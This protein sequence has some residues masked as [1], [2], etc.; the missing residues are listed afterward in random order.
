[1]RIGVSL[2]NFRP[3]KVGGIET[4]Y[5]ELIRWLPIC[6]GSANEI[7]FFTGSELADLFGQ[8]DHLH[9]INR[10]PFQLSLDRVVEAFTPCRCLEIE[11]MIQEARVDVMFYPHQAMFPINCPVPSVVTVHDLQHVY[12]PSHFSMLDRAYRATV[13]KRS[14]YAP[15]HLI[16]I[17]RVT[18]ESLN[19]A[20]GINPDKIS[21]VHHGCQVL[22]VSVVQSWV[23]EFFGSY[24]YYPAASFPH[25][26]HMELIRSFARL[27]DKGRRPDGKIVF[28]GM[29]TGYWK[30]IEREIIEL[31]LE[32]D[33]IHVGFV[34][35]ED[36]LSLYKGSEA[37]LFPSTFEGFGIPVL[38]A[39]QF[40]KKII[41]SELEV[42]TEIG[43]QHHVD[44]SL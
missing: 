27:R 19:T 34:S 4:Y 20:F 23:G 30:T 44:V 37:V 24:Y 33:V 9:I 41:C 43:L 10:S 12:Y 22:D 40:E 14:L 16:A 32:Q 13:W 21:V 35:Y 39:A 36:V 2:F 15:S 6:A 31:G 26:G 18:A 42:F 3:G 28:S 38:E 11:R 25:K 1:M 29:K 17:S 7:I 8:V 5:R